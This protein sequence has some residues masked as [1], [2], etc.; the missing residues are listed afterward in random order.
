LDLYETKLSTI[1]GSQYE[2]GTVVSQLQIR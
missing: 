2:T 1:G